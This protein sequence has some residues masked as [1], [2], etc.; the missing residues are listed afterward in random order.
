MRS[1]YNPDALTLLDFLSLFD[2]Q[3]QLGDNGLLHISS[4]GVEASNALRLTALCDDLQGQL[5]P[6]EQSTLLEF[7]RDCLLTFPC[8]VE[9]IES[10][11]GRINT[12]TKRPLVCATKAY[13]ALLQSRPL[14]TEMRQPAGRP[15]EIPAEA[16]EY[17]KTLSN[18]AEYTSKKAACLEAAKKYDLTAKQADT[19]CR[20]LQPSH[21]P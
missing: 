20:Y 15:R 5:F 10:W 1:V 18:S 6:E 9:D 11:M 4:S 14:A 19:I 17:A 21:K 16:I 8:T 7:E 2:G 3:L 13:E 12:D